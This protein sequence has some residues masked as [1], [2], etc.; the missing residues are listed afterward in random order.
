MWRSVA[1]A[2]LVVVPGC[3]L[4]SGAPRWRGGSFGE[5]PFD[6]TSLRILPLTHV[7]EVSGRRGVASVLV[8]HVELKDRYGDTVKGLGK[9][10]AMLYRWASAEEGGVATQEARW[11]IAGMDDPDENAAL[12][13]PATRSYRVQ[14]EA[15]GW[16]EGARAAGAR[17]VVR[18]TMD[19]G[20]GRVL[21]DE[22][23]I[24]S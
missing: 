2:A 9:M 15:P 11:E 23:A 20:G 18:V 24:R 10:T 16:F 4:E 5:H 22:W 8:L 13:D 12:F 14:L 19:L 7:D 3:A 6:A 17:L 21:S 1:A